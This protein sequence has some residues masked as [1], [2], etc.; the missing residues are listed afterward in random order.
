M[1]PKHPPDRNVDTWSAGGQPMASHKVNRG[2]GGAATVDGKEKA[3]GMEEEGLRKLEERLIEDGAV[4][5]EVGRLRSWQER[6]VEP[7]VRC[8]ACES[9]FRFRVWWES[10]P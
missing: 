5:Q 3:R 8:R 7:G 9:A 1:E 4:K 6:I 10:G 2:R